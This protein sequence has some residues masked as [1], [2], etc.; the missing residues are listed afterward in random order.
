MQPPIGASRQS[1]QLLWAGGLRTVENP[2]PDENRDRDEA[3]SKGRNPREHV[4]VTSVFPQ[5]PHKHNGTPRTPIL[6]NG[7]TGTPN[8]VLSL[9]KCCTQVS[10]KYRIANNKERL[11][12]LFREFPK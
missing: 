8:L 10:G 2:L 6:V 5:N 9:L 3:G 11:F 1:V 7:P 4:N 12:V